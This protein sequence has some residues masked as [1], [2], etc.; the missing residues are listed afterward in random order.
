METSLYKI[1][2]KD[3]REYR[4]F[5]ANR[6]QKE[7]MHKAWNELLKKDNETKVEVMTNGIHTIKQFEDI[8]TSL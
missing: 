5:C 2:F 4:V 1:T 6:K 8:K 3:G 7:R